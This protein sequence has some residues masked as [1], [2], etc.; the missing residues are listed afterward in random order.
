M[1]GLGPFWTLANGD[2]N[3]CGHEIDQRVPRTPSESSG[4]IRVRCLECQTINRFES[5]DQ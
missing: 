2:C 4:P 1:G 3:E 5:G